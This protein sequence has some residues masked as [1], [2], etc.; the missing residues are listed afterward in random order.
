M[1]RSNT[2][3][4]EEEE[5][6]LKEGLFC[7]EEV[8]DTHLVADLSTNVKVEIIS[9]QCIKVIQ[10]TRIEP[11]PRPT[12]RVLKSISQK[13]Q[14]ND[15]VEAKADKGNTRVI[16]HREEYD[17]KI[18]DFLRD[19]NATLDPVFNFSTFNAVIMRNE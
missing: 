9:D 5:E 12:R 2:K 13:I 8:A 14:S 7:N 11:I 15:L 6:L 1:N 16:L 19:N 17:S 10:S 3:F 4:S 18:N